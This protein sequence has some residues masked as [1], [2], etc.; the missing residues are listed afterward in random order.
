MFTLSTPLLFFRSMTAPRLTLAAEIL[1]PRRQ[2][3]VLNRSIKR[4]QLDRRNQFFRVMLSRLRKNWIEGLIIVKPE[5][6]KEIR[7]LIQGMSHEN[8]LWG[9]PWI[10]SELR[11]LGFEVAERT[12]ANYR[13]KNARPPSQT[14]KAFIA[15]HAKQIAAVDSFTMPTIKFPNL[16]CFVILLHA[17]RRVIHFNGAGRPAGEWTARQ[18]IEAFSDNEAPRYLSRDRDGVYCEYFRNR[19]QGMGIEEA[20]TAPRSPSQNPYAELVIGGLRRECLDHLI[21]IYED[22]FRRILRECFDYYHNSRPHQSLERSSPIPRGIEAQAMC[23][24]IAIPQ[25]GGLRHLYRRSA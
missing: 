7:V 23:K 20:P 9:A 15:N 16:F 3:T 19:V 11:L 14:W 25:V 2:L 6:D 18:I 13:I 4:P 22:H 5:I 12:V 21:V 1:A 8:P 10:Q 24:V 17:R